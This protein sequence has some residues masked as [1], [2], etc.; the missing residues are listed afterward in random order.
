VQ[1]DWTARENGVAVHATITSGSPGSSVG[2]F[3]G[4]SVPTQYTNKYER[5]EY[6]PT[7]D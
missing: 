5:A 1:T 6:R 7:P 2:L 4:L 3:V